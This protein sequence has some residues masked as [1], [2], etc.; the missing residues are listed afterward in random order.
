M[1]TIAIVIIFLA[2][3]DTIARLSK[4]QQPFGPVKGS[5]SPDIAERYTP[6]PAQQNAPRVNRRA[7]EI[8]D[9]PIRTSPAGSIFDYIHFRESRC[10]QDPRC[11]RG[12]IGDAGERGEYQVTPI[13]VEDVKRLS[14][15]TIDPYDND[16]CRGGITVWL[17]HYVP[18]VG[19]TTI[20]QQY[21]LYRRGAKGYR[22]WERK[23]KD[24]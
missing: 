8:M 6:L 23:G 18:I 13:F 21:E 7:T 24:Q 17:G 14:G 22:R 12:I 9:K 11:R 4:I 5:V 16:S 1:R 2:T 20:E 15:L 3:C 10:G 19:A